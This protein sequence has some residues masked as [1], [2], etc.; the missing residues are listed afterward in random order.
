MSEN[1][2]VCVCV[3]RETIYNT[4]LES[5]FSVFYN[6]MFECSYFDKINSLSTDVRSCQTIA[7]E[8]KRE[9]E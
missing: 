5:D 4:I 7:I 9:R 2:C 6:K 8:R 3:Y 1:V